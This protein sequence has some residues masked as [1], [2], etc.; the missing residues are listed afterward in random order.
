MPDGGGGRATGTNDEL[1]RFSTWVKSSCSSG[2]PEVATV[3]PRGSSWKGRRRDDNR[4][5]EEDLGVVSGYVGICS[6]GPV[7]D[8]E[9]DRDTVVSMSCSTFRD[10]SAS[11][12]KRRVDAIAC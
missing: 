5:E 7:R 9:L 10:T 6:E 4:K 12:T 3:R 2:R 1:S 8:V 11:G